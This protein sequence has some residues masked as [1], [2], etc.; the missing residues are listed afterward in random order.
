[1]DEP[2]CPLRCR[3]ARMM[4]S[5]LLLTALVMRADVLSSP[6]QWMASY[7]AFSGGES[8][9]SVAVPVTDGALVTVVMPGANAND[10]SLRSGKNGFPA[11]LIGHDPVT[12]LAF[13][14]LGGA[15]AVRRI[16]WLVDARD[17]VGIPLRAEGIDGPVKCQISGWVKQIGG[18]VLPLA[19]MRVNFDRAVPPVGTPL[20]EPQGKVAGVVFQA[21]AGGNSGYA[22]PAEAVHRVRRDVCNGG[23]LVRGWLGLTLHSE[24]KMPRIVRVLPQSPAA[25]AGVLPG[26]VLTG[27]G[28]RQ[29]SDYADAAN[30]FFYLV[31]GEVTRV[32][33]LREGR[34]IS[35]S[36]TPSRPLTD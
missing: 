12:R 26:D 29:I 13:V 31:P 33:L 36:L 11:R 7:P 19:L 2:G 30:A 23:S 1:M 10:P 28:S 34:T 14:Q 5:W 6:S 25:V 35:L 17:C 8:C 22:I 18:K 9:E 20:I 24:S 3:K 21:A 4:L 15:S 16:E 32:R 27:V